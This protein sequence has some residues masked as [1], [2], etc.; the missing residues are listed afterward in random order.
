MRVPRSPRRNAMLSSHSTVVAS[1]D[2][3]SCRLGPEAAILHLGSGVYYGLNP[4]GARVWALLQQPVMVQRLRETLLA[5][6]D[7][8]P[9]RLQRDLT[10]LLDG[11]VA[12][13]LIEVLHDP[14][15]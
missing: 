10:D 13:G 7:V 3:V 12:E 5:E 6:Y 8:A 1:R 4:V 14:A 15:A 9:D 11:L 2:Q